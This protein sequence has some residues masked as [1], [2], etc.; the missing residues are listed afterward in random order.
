LKPLPEVAQVATEKTL[1]V[2]GPL[3]IRWR[4]RPAGSDGDI[5]TEPGIAGAID[6]AHAAGADRAGHVIGANARADR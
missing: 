3:T 1:P 2:S 6:L 5:A 4:P